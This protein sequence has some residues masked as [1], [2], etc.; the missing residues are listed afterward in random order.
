MSIINEFNTLLED[1]CSYLKKQ[2]ENICNDNEEINNKYEKASADLTEANQLL[3]V[4][5]EYEKAEKALE[6]CNEQRTEMAEKESLLNKINNAYV[7]KPY[8]N[9]YTNAQN[10]KKDLE[11]KKISDVLP[12]SFWNTNFW[13]YWQTMFASSAGRA[14][15]K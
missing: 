4:F 15:W 12:E 13:L 1:Y 6:Q 10:S 9:Y 14:L 7:I 5:V 11:N 3:T 8:Y 2:C